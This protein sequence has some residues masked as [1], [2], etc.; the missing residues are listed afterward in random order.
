MTFEEL[1]AEANAMG[2]GLYKLRPYVKILP[3]VCGRKQIALWHVPI[4][5]KDSRGIERKIYGY[6]MK[7]SNCRKKSGWAKTEREAKILWNKSITGE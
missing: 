6:E 7:C 2:Y 3:C 4:Y 5:T 1:K